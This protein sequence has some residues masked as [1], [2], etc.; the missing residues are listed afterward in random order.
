MSSETSIMKEQKIIP[1]LMFDKEAEEAIDYYASIFPDST[2]S[3]REYYPNEI[4]GLGG[5]LMSAT[6]KIAAQEF[7]VSNG[8]SHFSFSPGFSIFVRCET[9]EEIDKYWS[10]LTKNGEEQPCGW[11]LDKYGMSWQIIPSVL[12]EYLQDADKEKADRVMK[13]MLQMTKIDIAGLN[14]AY[15]G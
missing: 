14:K 8:G 9:Q 15:Q 11:V 13:A 3:K 1:F 10:E 2:V 6:F 7:F 12:H 5:K 4:P